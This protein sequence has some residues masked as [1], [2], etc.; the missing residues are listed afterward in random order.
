MQVVSLTYF[1]QT[2]I[3]KNHRCN[4]TLLEDAGSLALCGHLS[5]HLLTVAL[6]LIQ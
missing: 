2:E 1:G 5:V 6:R 4:K 3:S